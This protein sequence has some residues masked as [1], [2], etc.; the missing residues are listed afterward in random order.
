MLKVFSCFPFAGAVLFFIVKLKKE[1]FR[2]GIDIKRISF[3]L[4]PFLSSDCKM[5]NIRF[6]IFRFKWS[7]L[8]QTPLG[9]L[10][11][12][13]KLRKANEPLRKRIQ[14]IFKVMRTSDCRFSIFLKNFPRRHISFVIYGFFPNVKFIICGQFTL[15]LF[16]EG[17]FQSKHEQEFGVRLINSTYLE[18]K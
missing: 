14:N 5:K 16:C 7:I 4:W 8:A 11:S 2:N 15:W 9:A 12:T 3:F 1:F 6:G 17:Q 13:L 18:L 10:C